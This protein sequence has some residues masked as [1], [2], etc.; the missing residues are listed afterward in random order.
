MSPV[1]WH[2]TK[3]IFDTAFSGT[4]PGYADLLLTKT[5]A[6]RLYLSVELW[7]EPYRYVWRLLT[8]PYSSSHIK[9]IWQNL[10]PPCLFVSVD[11]VIEEVWMSIPSHWASHLWVHGLWRH[12]SKKSENLG[13]CGRQNIFQPSLKT[14]EG[15]W[16]FGCAVKAISSLG[17]RSPCLIW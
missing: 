13:R 16:I 2:F 3:F 5:I 11:A 12:N 17:V 1:V 9:T 15:D 7:N 6:C 4:V 10:L 8:E 14:R